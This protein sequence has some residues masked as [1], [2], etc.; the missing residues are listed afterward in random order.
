MKQADDTKRLPHCV[1]NFIRL[2]NTQTH[3]YTHLFTQVIFGGYIRLFNDKSVQIIDENK[4]QTVNVVYNFIACNLFSKRKKNKIHT[5]N[6]SR[7]N[8]QNSHSPLLRN[9]KIVYNCTTSYMI[10]IQHCVKKIC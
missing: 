6:E 10:R 8:N 9:S 1:E 2:S 3:K 7:I 4:N 5:K